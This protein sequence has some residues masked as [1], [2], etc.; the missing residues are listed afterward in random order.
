[1]YI[2][3]KGDII[4]LDFNP[5]SGA[6]IRKR[7]PAVVI[8]NNKYSSLTGLVVVCPITHATN[9]R[10]KDTGFLVEIEESEQVDGYINPLQFHTFDFQAR[11]AEPLSKLN[12]STLNKVL[13]IVNDVINAK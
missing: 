10:L 9:N 4:I 3:D 2:P 11:K 5:S 7:R 8:S 12:K 6:E 13:M 1:M